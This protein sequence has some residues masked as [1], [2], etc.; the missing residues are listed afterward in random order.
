MYI[1]I[2]YL[3]PFFRI[4]IQTIWYKILG[5]PILCPPM[6][7]KSPWV[8]SLLQTSVRPTLVTPTRLA[9][10]VRWAW[11]PKATW[12]AEPYLVVG[13]LHPQD[14]TLPPHIAH[15]LQIFLGKWWV[16]PLA[17]RPFCQA[18]TRI[19]CIALKKLIVIC[20]LVLSFEILDRVSKKSKCS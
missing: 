5:R 11:L 12:W 13:W 7:S 20:D 1:S 19:R 10:T 14:L 2:I 18:I 15:L 3:I 6:T 8:D 16:F 9:I 4:T 17:R